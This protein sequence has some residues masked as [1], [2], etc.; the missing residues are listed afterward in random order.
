MSARCGAHDMSVAGRTGSGD[1]E[2]IGPVCAV[3][4]HEL[5]IIGV[6]TR[7]K[8]HVLCMDLIRACAVFNHNACHSAVLILQ[9][10]GHRI[11]VSVINVAGQDCI[12]Q[13]FID[14]DAVMLHDQSAENRG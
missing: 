3:L 9:K 11:A 14:A 8:D 4:L 10:T 1:L 6:S 2:G 5:L 13:G 12:E 7:G